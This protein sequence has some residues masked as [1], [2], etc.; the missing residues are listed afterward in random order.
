MTT[1]KLVPRASGEGAMGV[2]DNA[3]GEAYYDTGN[4]NKGLFVKGSGIEDVIAN[5]VT[6]G[7]LGGEWTKAVNGLDIY[8]NGGNV[9][10]GTTDPGNN[11]LK[12]AGGSLLAENIV[13]VVASDSNMVLANPTTE[14]PYLKF[15]G[16]N[17]NTGLNWSLGIDDSD[18]NDE[19]NSLSIKRWNDSSLLQDT[20][21]VVD[22]NGNVGIGT[23]SPDARL[24]VSDA[25]FPTMNLTRKINILGSPNGAA[26]KIE[27][28]ALSNTTP[29]MGGAMGF[30][31]LDSD[32]AGPGTN[33][34]GYLYF[35][36]KNS[37]ASLTEKMR[38]TSA[39]NV[40]I[41]TPDPTADLHINSKATQTAADKSV[42][43]LRFQ[44]GDS[45][46][47]S[48]II[49]GRTDMTGATD[50]TDRVGL[51]IATKGD[52]RMRITSAGNVGIGTPDPGNLLHVM[53]DAHSKVLIQGGNS[54][55]IGLQIKQ[56]LV[57]GDQVWQLQSEA[58]GT[59]LQIR[60]GTINTVVQHM[61]ADGNVG[62]GTT[63]PS[64][65][66]SIFKEN[67]GTDSGSQDPA[68]ASIEVLTKNTS[69]NA[70]LKTGWLTQIGCYS[71]MK[72]IGAM[73]SKN[74]LIAVYRDSAGSNEAAILRL[75]RSNHNDEQY[76]WVDDAG[77][78]RTSVTS[79]DT[80][81]TLG[82]VVGTQTSD[83]RIKNIEDSFEYGL[84]DVLKLKPI[85]FT[86]KEQKDDSRKLG[87]GAQSVQPIIPESV[88]D[89]NECIDGYDSDPE[90]DSGARQ[91]P[92]S[93][94]T[95]LVM[96]Y[97]QLI[98]VLTKAI[99]EQQ[100]LIEDLRSEVEALKNK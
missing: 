21:F 95:K 2:T 69:V 47:N 70:N 55:A 26:A 17:S 98:P 15:D 72:A 32:G 97:T 56:P 59:A 45:W 74:A 77:L 68:F 49:D 65:Q 42:S 79:S 1:K 14:Q 92:K 100:Q 66:L 80:G 5:T 20:P 82:T 50:Y 88:Y 18:L 67:S 63:Q 90:D 13:S 28:G 51:M 40:G 31:L 39:G 36:T 8:Y 29:S 64:A 4:F 87:F 73:P 34:E 54:H 9:G 22:S 84:N 3:W 25:G 61:N 81:S 76:F 33:T 78:F 7:G 24:H 11:R 19:K 60:N 16:K 38:I 6:Q 62:I 86:F 35:E 41:G 53:G 10:I 75:S 71:H 96:E 58:G 94:Q 91:I 83:E 85:A 48:V 46:D 27:G 30:A 52:E 12:I 89:S 37:G 44:N 99:Q 57:G 23:T 43:A 93:D